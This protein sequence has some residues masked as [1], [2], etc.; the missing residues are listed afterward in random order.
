MS[1]LMRFVPSW[2]APLLIAMASLTGC[3]GGETVDAGCDG[4]CAPVALSAADVGDVVARAVAEA[5]ARGVAGTVA[6]VDRSGN[7]L[8]VFRMTGAR[9]T[10]TIASPYARRGGLENIAF[11]PASLSAVSK[12][13]TG[14]YLSSQ[15][16]A[17]STRTASHIVQE[18]FNPGERNQPGGP[19][20]GVQFS[21]LAC[22]D[23]TLAATAGS[24]GPKRSPLGLS[25]D[26]GG[27][28]LYRDGVLVGGVGVEVDGRYRFDND[29]SDLDDSDD[30]A[31]A[32]AATAAL[33]TPVTR[34]A[35]HIAADGKLL[36]YSDVSLARSSGVALALATPPALAALAGELL[37]V[38]GYFDATGG[39]LAGTVFGTPESGVRADAT[40]FPGRDAF[41]LVDAFDAPRYPPQ[42]G[43]DG[44]GA[45]GADEVRSI[46]DEALGVASRARAQIRRPLGSAAQ[47]TIA[48]VDRNGVLLGLARTRD[49]PVFG[50]DVSV[51]KARTA[52][53]FSSAKAAA[54]LSSL[55]PA[56]YLA[57]DLSGGLPVVEARK[58][59]ADYLTIFR[60]FMGDARA[61]ANGDIAYS[62]R[63]VGN[64][65][66]PFFPDGISDA[67]PGP[68]SNPIAE[69]SP[70]ATGFQL[71]VAYNRI[72]AHAAFAAGIA[73]TDV[74]AG[75]SG[76]A[77]A[78]A[79]GNVDP[80]AN[81][82]QIFPG[83][84]PVYRDGVLVGAVGVSGDGVDQD[85]MIGFLGV[86]R[87]GRAAGTF[88]HAPP[89][90]R[91]DTLAPRGS[92]LRYVQCPQAPFNDGS[93]QTPCAGL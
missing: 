21:Q 38:P 49:A 36:R 67:V 74:S 83:G 19:L 44:P 65:A 17:F 66:R 10:V 75:C 58:E 31:V 28:P 6:V 39:V 8:A 77:R 55:P 54:D 29:I 88:G 5:Q 60:V 26:P 53:F 24:V 63:A 91:A 13:I 69:W 71:D 89:S 56:D 43:Q 51:Q 16:N 52:A 48:V 41:V 50:I 30:E 46:L 37:S 81:G 15:G 22:S 76:M 20:F 14:A 85:D 47:V 64:L 32:W 2:I 25:A 61:L 33:P 45:L 11:L 73:G 62:T 59:V 80:L 84:V 82:A 9:E 72:T 93:G 34:R 79:S 68:L 70:F 3:S 35:D 40:L 23:V 90:R 7:V 12:A 86:D 1:R 27:F 78:T 18:F 87:A 4:R 57:A 92:H 42:S